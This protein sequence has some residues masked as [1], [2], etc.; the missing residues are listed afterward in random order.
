MKEVESLLQEINEFF[1]ETFFQQRSPFKFFL[2]TANVKN[3]TVETQWTPWT[4]RN[5]DPL[6][7][8]KLDLITY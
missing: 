4:N 7:M 3:Q 1:S 6:P 5:V 2:K 8:W